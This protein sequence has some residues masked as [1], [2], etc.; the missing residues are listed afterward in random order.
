MVGEGEAEKGFWAGRGPK[1]ADQKYK[2]R[3]INLLSL[4]LGMRCHQQAVR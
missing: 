3:S 1:L 2:A 4:I